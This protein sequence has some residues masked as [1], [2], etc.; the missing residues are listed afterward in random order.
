MMY[1]RESDS[2]AACP[3]QECSGLHHNGT[4]F[5][6]HQPIPALR[7]KDAAVCFHARKS[8][9]CAVALAQR[10]Q[11]DGCHRWRLATGGFRDHGDGRS[12][13]TLWR[14][15]LAWLKEHKS[16]ELIVLASG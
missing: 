2:P 7:R 11:I 14:S 8:A 13:A 4:R 1:R 12:L 10:I 3:M 9:G 15:R 16:S 6:V 5:H